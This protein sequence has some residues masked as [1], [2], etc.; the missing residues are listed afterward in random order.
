M[1]SQSG[2]SDVL[3]RAAIAARR[4]RD[5]ELEKELQDPSMVELFKTILDHVFLLPLMELK[6]NQCTSFQGC[7]IL[8]QQNLAQPFCFSS[9][10]P[11]LFGK[12][13]ISL[14]LTAIGE[15][16][17]RQAF[18]ELPYGRHLAYFEQTL[19]AYSCVDHWTCRG[20]MPLL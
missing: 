16:E 19:S 1:H 13:F 4:V 7:Q 10:T 17:F 20:L 5:H 9:M 14:E 3:I 2:K 6:L 11:R 12:T 8:T 15:N 18:Q